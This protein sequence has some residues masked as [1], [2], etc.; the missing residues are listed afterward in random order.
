MDSD[1]ATFELDTDMQDAVATA[2]ESG[3]F[4]TV[5]YNGDDGFPHVS[6]R[7]SVQVFG[8]QQLAIWVRK[9]D[10]GLSAT[11]PRRPEVTVFYMD[12]MQRGVVYTFYGHGRVDHDPSTLDKVWAA[13]PQGEQAQDPD[14]NG[15]A[16]VVD[17]VKV[18]A[19][20]RRPEQNFV[21]P[22]AED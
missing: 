14:R 19:Q 21:L 16:V 10:D 6:R 4:I 22:R 18:V 9:R 20:G 15:T 12:L 5:A 13:T 3:N 7:G 2:F 8:P 17:L 11:V 1:A